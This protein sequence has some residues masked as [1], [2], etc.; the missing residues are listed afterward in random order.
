MRYIFILFV[1]AAQTLS[2]QTNT[3]TDTTAKYRMVEASCGQ[4]QFKMK[5]K[6][7]CDLAVR[8][9]GKAYWVE[10]TAIDKHGDAHATDGFC[11]SIRRAEVAGEVKGNK[12]LVT[13]FK[14]LPASH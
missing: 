2:A 8:I 1:L 7:G 5:D 9:D 14:L 13:H 6:E 11:N 3:K 12:F 10:G 4:C